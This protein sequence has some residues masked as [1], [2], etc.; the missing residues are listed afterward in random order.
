MGKDYYSIL[1]VDKKA[2]EETIKRTYK[3]Q[4]LKWHPDRNPADK[5]NAEQKFKELAE[6]YEVLSDKEKKR[7]YDLNGEDGLKG[8]GVFGRN[9]FHFNPGRA[10]DIFAQFFG[11]SSPF[12]G[13]F[14]R[15]SSNPAD[16]F[17]T[18]INEV[19][20]RQATPFQQN[21]PCTLED[22]YNGCIKKM[23][24]TKD[25]LDLSG[26]T[27]QVEKVVTIQVQKGWKAGTKITFQREGDDI[28]PGTAPA[29]IV[30][31]LEEKLH[32]I[33]RRDKDD[34]RCTAEITLQEA[35]TGFS[36]E[37]RTLDNRSLLLTSEEVV[38]PS[39]L[40]TIEG[41]GMPLQ[42]N[43]TQ[44]GR[45]HINFAIKFPKVLTGEQKEKVNALLSGVTY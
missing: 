15:N 4:A 29:D 42:K 22:L 23:K 28:K 38:S 21:F 19:N 6:A 40:K 1:G 16:V 27:I 36:Q 7:V 5:D 2:D 8:K 25:V 3:K 17:A 12:N 39:T 30:F 35:L 34:L 26:N 45:L 11:G 41:E 37:I 33:F 32:P 24:I 10:E 43:P 18:F 9:G 14:A 31:T 20:L 13:S 44:R